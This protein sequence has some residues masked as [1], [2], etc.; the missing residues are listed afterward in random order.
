MAQSGPSQPPPAESTTENPIVAVGR[1]VKSVLGS[2]QQPSV[3]IQRGPSTGKSR[4]V[5]ASKG[6]AEKYGSHGRAQGPE[7]RAD[8]AGQ[9]AAHAGTTSSRE[10]TSANRFSGP[11]NRIRSWFSRKEDS[12]ED[13]SIEHEYDPDTVDLLDVMGK[14]DQPGFWAE[15]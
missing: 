11:Q 4:R 3:R 15:S 5:A 13:E 14:Q 10:N 8:L 12:T 9:S 7:S 6:D 2:H 1:K